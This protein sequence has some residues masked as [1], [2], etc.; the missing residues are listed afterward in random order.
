MLASVGGDGLNFSVVSD[1]WVSA[2]DNI[3]GFFIEVK[4]VGSDSGVDAGLIEVALDH[5][6]ETLSFFFN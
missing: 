5:F 2:F 6:E 1:E 4:I 3:I